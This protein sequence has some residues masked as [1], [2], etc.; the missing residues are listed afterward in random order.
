MKIIEIINVLPG[1]DF[2]QRKKGALMPMVSVSLTLAIL[3]YSLLFIPVKAEACGWWGDG[4][5]EQETVLVDSD[6]KPILDEEPTNDDSPAALTQLGNRYRKGDGV[7]KNYGVEAA[8]WYRLAAEQGDGYAQHSLG[9]MYR[10]GQGVTMDLSEA[11]KWIRKAAEQGHKGAFSD[12]GSLYWEGLGV[13]GN[14]VLAYMWWKIGATRGDEKSAKLC[15]MAA[16]KMTPVKV[17]KAK[18]MAQDWTPKKD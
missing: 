5:D 18:K 9:R 13:P 17:D 6:G 4:D 12:M 16:R 15:D 1:R 10:L 2:P 3:I 14:D 11:A 7:S 8:K